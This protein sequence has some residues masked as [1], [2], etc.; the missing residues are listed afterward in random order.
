M[1]SSACIRVKAVDAFYTR[2][3]EEECPRFGTHQSVSSFA[4]GIMSVMHS[5]YPEELRRE[6]V[7]IAWRN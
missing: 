2:E 5:A 4:A 3:F 1:I 6:V 7:A